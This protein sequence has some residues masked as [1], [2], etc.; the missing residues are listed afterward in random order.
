ML[1]QIHIG[2]K[3]RNLIIDKVAYRVKTIKGNTYGTDV[4]FTKGLN[5]IYGPNSVGKTSLITGIVYALGAEKSLGIFQNKQNPFKPEFYSTINNEIITESYVFLTI[6]NDVKTV[7]IKRSIIGKTDIV[8][9][10]EQNPDNE[11]YNHIQLIASGEGVFSDDGLQKYLFDFL[12]WNIVDVP[13]YDSG[14][15]KLYFENIVPLF[16]IEQ[17]AGWSQIQARQVTRYGIRDVKKVAFEYLMGL[18]RFKI[19]LKE[20]RKREIQELLAKKNDLLK[21][22]EDELL[23]ITNGTKEDDTIL[24]QRTGISKTSIYEVIRIQEDIY[25]REEKQLSGLAE[26][27]ENSTDKEESLREKLKI[28]S[29][30]IRKSSEEY[31]S[32]I[33]EINS[34]EGYIDRIKIN[35]SKNKQLKKLEGLVKELNLSSCP[36]CESTLRNNDEG[37]CVLCNQKAVN[38]ISTPEENLEFLE[39]E[40][41]TF[42]KVRD[43]KKLE[44]RKV[45]HQ[46]DSLKEK[47]VSLIEDIDHQIET[48]VG[49]EL[50]KYR[51]KIIEL[52]SLKKDVQLLKRSA[53]RW[54]KLDKDREQIRVL[55]KELE[56][57]KSDIEKYQESPN[58]GTTLNSILS[59]FKNNVRSIRLLKGKDELVNSIK[60][61]GS[62]HYLPYLEKYDLY[63]ISSSSDNVRIIL[64]YY[65]A[66]LQTSVGLSN[67]AIKFPNF[68]LLDEPKQQNLD[69]VDLIA[70]IEIIEQLSTKPI[71]VILT[72]YSEGKK[73]KARFSKYIR[74]EMKNSDDYLL[75]K[76][77]KKRN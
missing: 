75:K 56:S 22:R 45:R 15:S 30:K 40:K 4:E 10:R 64:S 5:I 53:E 8:I 36:V 63:N 13:T 41:S 39:D 34:Y 23:I 37:N 62:D 2:K 11:S 71:Q 14:S 54:G 48:Y 18:D 68:L 26:G 29:Y 44:L 60:L 33:Q 32:L 28:V 46:I 57:I 66:L 61:D 21:A 49:P 55:E 16:F 43:S 47:E 27:K 7:T 50:E 74:L 17:R 25:N 3:M 73:N 9:I 67:S 24:L 20:I 52:D 70:F 19:H 76:L 59:N 51:K 42:E 12:Q 77:P 58:D 72:T 69:E 6:S 31:N 1:S 35:Q 65:L 38:R